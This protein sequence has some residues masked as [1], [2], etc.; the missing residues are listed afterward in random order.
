MLT[1]QECDEL[2]ML[3]TLE[4]SMHLWGFVD[5]HE[6]LQTLVVILQEATLDFVRLQEAVSKAREDLEHVG[7]SAWLYF[8][9]NLA[10]IPLYVALGELTTGG[11]FFTADTL[12]YGAL[13]IP[14]IVVGVY[15]G[16]ILFRYLPQRAFLTIVLVLSGVGAARLIV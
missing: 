9:V 12:T 2:N 5:V 15:S 4:F 3:K 11:R 7:T 16:R 10:K 8:A 14:A 6:P 13:M 1:E